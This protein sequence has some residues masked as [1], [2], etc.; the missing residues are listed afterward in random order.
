M[1]PEFREKLNSVEVEM[2][3]DMEA[4]ELVVEDTWK[5]WTRWGNM[6]IE[7]RSYKRKDDSHQ[8]SH[9]MKYIYNERKDHSNDNP[10]VRDCT[11]ETHTQL[12]KQS[13]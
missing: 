12:T 6:R 10:Y 9:L 2:V 11:L 5:W 4:A 1:T 13:T 3:G 8:K 7:Q